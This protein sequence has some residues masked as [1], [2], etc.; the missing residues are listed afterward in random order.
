MTD[1]QGS[2]HVAII[3]DGNGRWAI[4]RGLLRAEGHRAGADAVRRVVEADPDFGLKVL[5]LYA[6]SSDNWQRPAAEVAT[7]LQLFRTFLLT[8]SKECVKQG[9]RLSVIVRGVRAPSPLLACGR[10]GTL[11]I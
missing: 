11:F 9:V 8:R 6:F 4:S 7:L 1:R 10:S 2:F 5:T 3:M